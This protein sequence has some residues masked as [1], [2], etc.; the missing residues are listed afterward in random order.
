[1]TVGVLIVPT[2]LHG[3]S[4]DGGASFCV[5]RVDP[6]EPTGTA[7]LLDPTARNGSVMSVC[8]LQPRVRLEGWS[9]VRTRMGLGA[10]IPETDTC[11]TEG[12]FE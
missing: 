9:T 8:L 3:P 4:V 10:V 11:H 2:S 1:M 5:L 6:M 12:N 7:P